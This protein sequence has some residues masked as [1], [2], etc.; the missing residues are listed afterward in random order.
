MIEDTTHSELVERLAT[1]K[2][3]RAAKVLDG[4]KVDQDNA[5]I[6]KLE[7]E[8]Q[9]R[10]EVEA[11]RLRRKRAAAQEAADKE[12]A[13]KQ[14]QLA[15]LVADD[16]ADTR[17]A[18][19]AA[20]KLAAAVSR[21][22]KRNPELARLSHEVS[23]AAVPTVLHPN[24]LN[25]RIGGRIAGI[26]GSAIRPRNK[27]GALEWKFVSLFPAEQSWSEEETKLYD[28]HVTPL[29]KGQSNGRS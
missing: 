9:I 16:L 26:L 21:R 29:T 22:L 19:D 2:Q 6:A 15:A 12:L 20:R 14:G 1:L 8:I 11:E 18:E 24:E 7:T 13:A 17:E 4:A 10:D 27:L 25:A 23:G 28:R 5:L 3:D